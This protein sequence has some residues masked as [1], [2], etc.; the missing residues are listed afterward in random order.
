[1]YS[2]EFNNGELDASI[3]KAKADLEHFEQGFSSRELLSRLRSASPLHPIL[4]L[5]FGLLTVTI[6]LA[7][8]AVGS[9][10]LPFLSNDVAEVVGQLDQSI[11]V[12]LPGVIAS[13]V[14]LFFLM[15]LGVHYLALLLARSAPLLPHEARLHQRLVSDV[16]QLEAQRSVQRRMTPLSATPR[17][18]RS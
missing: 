6:F 1:M 11:G 2:G 10:S 5:R 9:L 14:P 13:L 16:K 12:P 15:A 4:V 3:N 17:S 18:R 7:V 8:A